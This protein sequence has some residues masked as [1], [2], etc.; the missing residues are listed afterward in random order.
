MF[1]PLLSY[2]SCFSVSDISYS[3]ASTSQELFCLNK[4][5][6]NLSNFPSFA[7]LGMTYVEQTSII[8]AYESH[9]SACCSGSA[10]HGNNYAHLASMVVHHHSSL[11]LLKSMTLVAFM[12]P[13]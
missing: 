5:S 10:M 1:C 4:P 7:L 2:K 3:N 9:Y 13:N 6:K 8:G 11:P 12:I